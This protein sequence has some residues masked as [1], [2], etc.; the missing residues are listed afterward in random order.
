MA[1]KGLNDVISSSNVNP[2]LTGRGTQKYIGWKFDEKYPDPLHKDSKSVWDIYK[3]HDPEYPNSWLTVPIIFDK[4]TQKIVNNESAE[5]IAFLNTEF[6]EFAKNPQL[7]LN[8]KDKQTQSAMQ[9]WNDLIYPS[10]NDGVYR[11]GFA[12]S[13]QAY[14]DAL[15]KMF[16]CLDKME[17]HLS[18]SLFLCGDALTLSDVRAW[19]TLIRF[20][21]VYFCHFKCNLKMLK[22]DYPNIWAYTRH[23]YQMPDMAATV[24]IEYTKTH[25]YASHHSVNPKGI[26]PKGPIIDYNEPHGRDKSNFGKEKADEKKTTNLM[27]QAVI[28]ATKEAMSEQKADE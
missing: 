11:C 22:V 14:E 20:D 7:D 27:K 13:Q 18:Q 25:Y 17:K 9:E 6:N 5:I 12:N 21:A 2:L 24:D 8:P 15:D 3:L 19:V 16:K 26:V 4:K 28:E 1:M 23:I 10:L